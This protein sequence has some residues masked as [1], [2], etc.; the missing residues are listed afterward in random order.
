MK[1]IN[2]K[3]RIILLVL[4]LFV[5]PFILAFSWAKQEWSTDGPQQ[6]L[7]LNTA[8]SQAQLEERSLNKMELY[9][10]REKE[11]K[12][13]RELIRMDPYLKEKEDERKENELATKTGLMGL[14]LEEKESDLMEKLEQLQGQLNTTRTEAVPVA[15]KTVRQDFTQEKPETDLSQDVRELEALMD[16]MQPSGP[17]PELQQLEG[18]L[19][20]IL[21]VQHPERVAERYREKQLENPRFQVNPMAKA[22]QKTKEIAPSQNGFYGLEEGPVMEQE[23]DKAMVAELAESTVIQGSGRVK[24]KLLEAVEV[25]GLDLKR[26][27]TLY[28][29][30]KQEG[31]RVA[32]TISAIRSGKSIIPVA[33]EGHD[34]DGMPGIPISGNFRQEIQTGAGDALINGMPS[35]NAGM[36]FGDQMASAGVSA[37]KGLFRK[38]QKSAKITLKAGHPILLVNQSSI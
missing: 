5:L 13:Q 12:R 16:R 9:Q 33:L 38:Q 20:K 10:L 23:V 2:T 36:S 27:S 25:N 18:M 15:A 30:A 32:L 29:M 19:D 37:A 3:Q 1:T 24:I 17:D 22:K 4:P 28:G 35:M 11:T 34:F 26:G 21:D 6:E 14:G 7:R 8:L 31:N